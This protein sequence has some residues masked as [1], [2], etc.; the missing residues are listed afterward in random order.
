MSLQRIL[1][2]RIAHTVYRRVT[3]WTTGVRFPK[4]SGIS[5][6]RSVYTG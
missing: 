1:G 2:V 5:F 6:L 3:D 4:A